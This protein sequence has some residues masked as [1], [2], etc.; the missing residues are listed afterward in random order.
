MVYSSSEGIIDY[1]Q[2][3]FYFYRSGNGIHELWG[4]A[5][6]EKRSR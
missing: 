6:Q 4:S 2:T 1:E 5:G 3:D